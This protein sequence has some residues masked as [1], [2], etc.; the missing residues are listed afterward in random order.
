MTALFL[1]VG[2][3]KAAVTDVPEMSTEG[4]I[5]WY[6]I[7]NTRSTSGKYLYWTANGVKD[8]NTL[9]GASL[10]YF[11][12]EGDA[13]FIHNAATELLFSGAG[14]WTAE[15]VSC[16]ISET[17]HSS[18]AGVAIEF[19]GTA[20]NEQN[21][22]DGYTTYG[23]NDAGSIFVISP[24]TAS[25]E[26]AIAAIDVNKAAGNTI[27]GEYK[28]E[29]EAYNNLVAALA[30]LKTATGAEAV[31]AFESC[32]EIMANLTYVMPEAGK[33]Y[34]IECPIFKAAQGVSKGLNGTSGWNTIDLTDTNYYWSVEV[35][36][37][38]YA[39]KNLKTG[40]YLNGTSMSESAAYAKLA[41]LGEQ[42]FNIVVNG[43]TVHANGH[44]GGAGTSGNLVSWA[45][46]ANSASA[47]MFIEKADPTSLA[48]VAVTYSFTYG[49]EE[50]YTQTVS[51]LVGEEWP[52]I[53]VAFPYG[54]SASNK[55]EG[56]IAAEDHTDG[57]VTKV[58]ELSVAELPFVAAADVESIDTWYN[59]QMHSNNKKYIQYLADQ[60]YI[61]WADSEMDKTAK[62]SYVW[63]FVGNIFDG[64][65]M[66]NKAA[67][68]DKA[69][70]STGSGD[71]TFVAYADATSFVLAATS[72]TSE[73]AQGGFCL[74]YPGN[75]QYLN[76]QNGKVAH[77]GS[78]DA[79][80]T[81]T[82]AK[83]EYAVAELVDAF[84][85][86]AE[87]FVGL[88]GMPGLSSLSAV[89]EKWAEVMG[90]VEPLYGSV[91]AGEKAFKNDVEAA[92][93]EMT[94][95][96]DVV[97]YYPTYS[98]VYY[99]ACDLCETL[100][101]TSAEWAALDAVINEVYNVSQVTS[102]AELKAKVEALEKALAP[103]YNL[104]ETIE[105]EWTD[106]TN[107]GD[108]VNPD[109]SSLEAYGQVYW[110]ATN[111]TNY[112]AENGVMEFVAGENT[113]ASLVQNEVPFAKGTY[114]LTGKAYH[115]GAVNAVMFVGDKQVEISE[116]EDF[117][118]FAIEF[119]TEGAQ[120][121][122]DYL[123]LG[124]SCE[125]D[126]AEDLL[127]VGGFKLEEKSS[128]TL[129]DLFVEKAMALESLGYEIGQFATLRAEQQE[130][131]TETVMPLF[132]PVMGGQKVLKSEVAKAIEAIDAVMAELNPVAD[133]YK[134][135]FMDALFA[136]EE[137]KWEF[138]EESEE[139]ADLDA[140][141]NEA[142]NVAEV[143]TVA[144]LEA[145]LEA[146]KVVVELIETGIDNINADAETVIY[147]LSGRR[148]TE[149][150]KGGIYIVNGKKVVIK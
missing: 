24:A 130:V 48:E 92:M 45:G 53:T 142:N 78:T 84:K 19:S 15:G 85:T 123:N 137:L 122:M 18:K 113:S 38:T 125:F 89:S 43:T 22:A 68:T 13:C 81:F 63:A 62:D 26:A 8:A 149:M 73:G 87:A 141:I 31:A 72:E 126:N 32:A 11:T 10:F 80:S 115:K 139:Y 34:V 56:T 79:G 111:H 144:E 133:F 106:I 98:E 71:A 20:L 143:T 66:V 17:P 23:A 103:F 90:V 25:I 86:Q 27:M 47:W 129:R 97:A 55:P 69:V 49:G 3:V 101:P 94:A 5:K 96:Q 148:V 74:R 41:Y 131:M 138:D 59:V 124:Y 4:N 121:G 36:D 2:M 42:Q 52:A 30:V 37:G 67:T 33:F 93:A 100:D 7:S 146:L 65:K 114:R 88:Q 134:G 75:N 57:A 108:I 118:E 104:D 105:G 50:K 119:T 51:T 83:L 14:A 16:K 127:V 116:S 12:G 120:W 54:V 6:T 91:S 21:H 95:V 102:V 128:T 145:K 64:F 35:K 28:Y 140:A 1:C 99:G 112:D 110:N 58:I 40:T 82:I 117:V 46:S 70:K 44:N 107:N 29:E 61:E 132:E 136:A 147:D 76:A 9:S 135:D 77:W 39:L 60:T 150:T 109:L